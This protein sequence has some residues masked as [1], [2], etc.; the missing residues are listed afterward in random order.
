MS[1]TIL[2]K[3]I[4]YTYLIIATVI[5]ALTFNVIHLLTLKEVLAQSDIVTITLKAIT[6]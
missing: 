1:Q 6:V 4:N 5:V 3:G 2:N